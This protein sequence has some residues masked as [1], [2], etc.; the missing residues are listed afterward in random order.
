[1]LSWIA[2]QE[3]IG[4]TT[5]NATAATRCQCFD[6]T[7]YDQLG[8]RV[9]SLL[10]SGRRCLACIHDHSSGLS[11]GAP[12]A[13]APRQSLEAEHSSGHVPLLDK[14]G[15][16]F[17]LPVL[18]PDPVRKN[19]AWQSFTESHIARTARV[20]EFADVPTKTFCIHVTLAVTE[21]TFI[22]QDLPLG[23]GPEYSRRKPPSEVRSLRAP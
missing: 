22:R 9:S 12:V 7:E 8:R 19:Q 11:D 18:V 2:A 17:L 16:N 10:F 20:Q 5:F 14:L 1:M 21:G 15:R 13:N 23:G 6:L 4:Q 3:R